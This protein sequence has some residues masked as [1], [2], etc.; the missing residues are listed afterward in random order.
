M[1]WKTITGQRTVREAAMNCE[2]CNVIEVLHLD[3]SAHNLW[4]CTGNH[5]ELERKSQHGIRYQSSRII[6]RCRIG[7]MRIQQRYAAPG[8]SAR[9]IRLLR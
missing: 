8:S 9:H 6:K 4:V 2:V 7:W 1:C 3:A 5:R